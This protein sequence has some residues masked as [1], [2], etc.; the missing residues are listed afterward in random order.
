M[1]RI[2]LLFLAMTAVACPKQPEDF[3]I[4]PSPAP[5][6]IY[7]GK[8]NMDVEKVM[9]TYHY[10]EQLNPGDPKIIQSLT[11]NLYDMRL[12]ISGSISGDP[13][14]NCRFERDLTLN[15]YRQ[16]R[17]LYSDIELCKMEGESDP[18]VSCC[19]LP[20][21]SVSLINSTKQMSLGGGCGY[22]TYACSYQDVENFADELVDLFHQDF[23]QCAVPISGP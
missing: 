21:F 3:P 6:I 15:E 4:G 9:L 13:S 20:M 18:Y 1:K 5:R 12:Q 2:A 10:Q 16:I 11:A 8:V 19:F 17:H 14:E 7:V 23:D 22:G